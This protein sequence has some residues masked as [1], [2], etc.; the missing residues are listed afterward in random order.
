MCLACPCSRTAPAAMAPVP[1]AAPDRQLLRLGQDLLHRNDALAVANRN[2]FD[3]AGVRVVNLLSAPG[4]GKTALLEHL[5]GLTAGPMAVIVGDLATD[6]DA[7]R[8]RAAGLAAVQITTG[9]ACHLEAAMVARAVDQLEHSG[10][11]LSSLRLLVI[12]NVGNLVCPAAY[13]LGEHLRLVLLAVTEGEDKPL[14]YPALFHSADLVVISKLDLAAAAPFDLAL[15]RRAI[16][17]VAP[18]ARI[19]AVSS[20]RGTGLA[21][22]AA[23]LVA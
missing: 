18:R 15:A 11:P 1:P 14:K 20:R 7:R 17:R 22:L 13:D 2:R 3:Q 5:G 9:Q 21:T 10:V 12:E 6:N 23:A 4:S 16:E 8:L 19:L